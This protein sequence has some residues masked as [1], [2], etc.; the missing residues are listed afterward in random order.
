MINRIAGFPRCLTGT[1]VLLLAFTW[2]L[3][4][5]GGPVRE[6]I[7][8]VVHV[9]NGDTPTGGVEVRSMEELWRVGDEDDEDI[10]FGLIPR[11][12]ADDQGNIH[13]LDSQ[14]NQVLVFSPA[15]ELRRTLFREGDGPGEIRQ[16]RDMMVMSDGRVGLIQHFPG[17]IIFVDREGNPAGRI[18]LGGTDGGAYSLTACDAAGDHYIVSAG[19]QSPGDT[20][21]LSNL[22]Y[23]LASYDHNGFPTQQYCES[24]AVYDYN[25]FVFSEREHTPTYW[26]GFAAAADGRT[27]VV[28]TRD[29]Y[30]IHVF[31]ADGKPEMVV[32]REYQPIARSDRE[33]ENLRLIYESALTQLPVEYKLVVERQAAALAYMQRGLRFRPDGSIWALSG[34]GVRDLPPGVLAVFDVFDRSGEFVKQVELRGPGDAVRDGI[35]F[36]G[37]DRIVVVKGY[38]ESLGAQFGSGTTAADDEDDGGSKLAVV[39]YSLSR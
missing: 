26:W 23:F 2:Q 30:A 1:A 18:N 7:D 22:H 25:N 10:L 19:T 4:L 8:G 15:G 6:T 29:E 34:R 39:C 28:P 11:V 21:S 37:E 20:P 13:V 38:M 5:A 17:V 33:Y 12:C 9:R 16:P 36:A 3:A 32:E 24:R 14:L 35:F 27:C 31:D